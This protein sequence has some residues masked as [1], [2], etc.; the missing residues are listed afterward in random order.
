MNRDFLVGYIV[1]NFY[2]VLS[3]ICIVV[4][5]LSVIGMLEALYCIWEGEE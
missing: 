2:D 1:D 3:G 4:I 5:I